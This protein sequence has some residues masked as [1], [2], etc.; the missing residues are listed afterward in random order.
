VGYQAYWLKRFPMIGSFLAPSGLEA[1]IA[2][3][4]TKS[5]VSHW[6][7]QRIGN[8]PR[9]QKKITRQELSRKI[10][11][12]TVL[13]WVFLQ[14]MACIVLFVSSGFVSV[15][16][17]LWST[18]ERF[19]LTPPFSFHHWDSEFPLMEHCHANWQKKEVLNGNSYGFSV[20]TDFLLDTRSAEFALQTCWPEGR[21]TRRILG[22]E[23]RICQLHPHRQPPEGKSSR[24][25]IHL[26]MI[27]PQF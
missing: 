19:T 17:I 7:A 12:E 26:R 20:C 18:W 8:A 4:L 14:W 27:S 3:V 5:P 6:S 11:S 23:S 13:Q 1:V 16:Y 24:S 22:D 15:L 2:C 10:D 21:R 25:R 9:P